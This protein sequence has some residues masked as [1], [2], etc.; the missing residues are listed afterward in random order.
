MR[1]WQGQLGIAGSSLAA[2]CSHATRS[3]RSTAITTRACTATAPQHSASPRSR[4]RSCTRR[5]DVHPPARCG[6]CRVPEPRQ[7]WALQRGQARTRA[8]HRRAGGHGTAA[9]LAARRE[10]CIIG[11]RVYCHPRGGTD[12]AMTKQMAVPQACHRA[13]QAHVCWARG[14]RGKA[15]PLN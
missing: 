5:H 8:L 7:R 2:T 3:Y 14:Q 13:V 11:T 10:A 1:Y 15:P 9:R 12:R 4:R 6:A